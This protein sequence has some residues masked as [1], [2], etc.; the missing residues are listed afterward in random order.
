MPSCT[1]NRDLF[2][3]GRIWNIHSDIAKRSSHIR[4]WI[5]NSIEVYTTAVPSQVVGLST[6]S[7][8]TV[9]G[10]RRPIGLGRPQGDLKLIYI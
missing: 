4:L 8:F 9:Q 10:S 2:S 5:R 6:S 7:K 3:R 1:N